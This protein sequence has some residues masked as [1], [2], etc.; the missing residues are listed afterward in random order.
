VEASLSNGVSFHLIGSG[1]GV[2]VRLPPETKHGELVSPMLDEVT[3]DGKLLGYNR[4]G[5]M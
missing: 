3:A 5:S 2:G 4:S 1:L